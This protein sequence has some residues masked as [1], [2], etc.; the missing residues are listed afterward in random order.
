VGDPVVPP[1]PTSITV[2]S[3]RARSG[4]GDL[5]TSSSQAPN[6]APS[7]VGASD[8]MLRAAESRLGG[9]TNTDLRRGT[10]EALPLDAAALDAATLVLVLHHLPSP[11]L[12]LAEAHRVL[13][14]G[15]RLLIVDMA[16]HEHEEYRQQMGHVWLGFS[17]E[18]L[19]R[20]LSQAGFDDVRMNALPAVTEAKGPALFAATATKSSLCFS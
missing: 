4:P 13:T 2:S 18:H 10:L 11:A 16:P 3:A 1:V 7:G 15:G 9:T 12:A 14:P 19:R 5:S 8:E 6:S 20:L 17:E